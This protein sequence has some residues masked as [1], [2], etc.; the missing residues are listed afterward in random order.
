MQLS[1]S[2]AADRGHARLFGAPERWSTPVGFGQAIASWE[3][4]RGSPTL[5]LP[6]SSLPEKGTDDITAAPKW[7]AMSTPPD[8]QP[9]AFWETQGFEQ[10]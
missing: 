8:Q 7:M 10:N 9:R 6:Q 2:L 1:P 3:E 5:K 4:H